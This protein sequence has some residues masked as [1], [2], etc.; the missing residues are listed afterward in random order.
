MSWADM[1]E[2]P[3]AR[4]LRTEFESQVLVRT[5]DCSERNRYFLKPN[6]VSKRTTYTVSFVMIFL[7]IHIYIHTHPYVVDHDSSI[8]YAA[9]E[10]YTKELAFPNQTYISLI[11]VTLSR[12]LRI[13]AG[14]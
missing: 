14:T 11:I 12:K 3:K 9:E 6:S 5:T 8:D 10:I 7:Y 1:I 2:H 4:R 13:A